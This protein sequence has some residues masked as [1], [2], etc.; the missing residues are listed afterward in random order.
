MW[1]IAGAG[2]AP[3]TSDYESDVLLLNYPAKSA[4]EFPRSAATRLGRGHLLTP[5]EGDYLDATFRGRRASSSARRLATASSLLSAC[6]LNATYVFT[7]PALGP[8]R[9]A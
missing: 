2:V 3:T 9:V 7:L 5:P 6:A 8:E 1:E 4:A